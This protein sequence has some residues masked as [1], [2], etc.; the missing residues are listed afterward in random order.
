MLSLPLSLKDGETRYNLAG[1]KCTVRP[2][3][4][5]T[6]ERASKRL[7]SCYAAT[8]VPQDRPHHSKGRSPGQNPGPVLDRA[9]TGLAYGILWEGTFCQAEVAAPEILRQRLRGLSTKELLAANARFRPGND[10]EDVEAATR[11]AIRSETW[12]YQA[13]S[14]EIAELDAHY[15]HRLVIEAALASILLRLGRL[16]SYREGPG[17]LL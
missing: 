8:R 15:L 11:L 4:R 3:C 17:L 14:E 9:Y 12:G 16:V 10:R 1:S 7:E 13:H 6:N 5:S 2:D